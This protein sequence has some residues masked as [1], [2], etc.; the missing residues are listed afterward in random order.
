MLA[1]QSLA[2]LGL[3]RSGRRC[4]KL[5]KHCCIFACSQARKAGIEAARTDRRGVPDRRYLGPSPR[6]DAARKAAQVRL[7]IYTTHGKA[8]MSYCSVFLHLWPVLWKS[9]KLLTRK[10]HT[11]QPSHASCADNSNCSL[12]SC[13]PRMW[14]SS[15]QLTDLPGSAGRRTWWT[16]GFWPTATFGYAKYASLQLTGGAFLRWPSKT[17]SLLL[18]LTPLQTPV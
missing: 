10:P 6:Q 7:L 4:V 5:L 3:P 12:Q 17:T 18:G 8:A 9:C 16:G 14:D 15:P 1:W 13:W 2:S 11:L